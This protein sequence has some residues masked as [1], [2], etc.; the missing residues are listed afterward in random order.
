MYY[1][2]VSGVVV[3]PS[4]SIREKILVEEEGCYCC[5]QLDTTL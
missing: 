5:F 2:E 1:V 4:L 3:S